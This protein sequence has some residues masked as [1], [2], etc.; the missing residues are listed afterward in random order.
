[1]IYIFR[2]WRFLRY[3]NKRSRKERP[4]EAP[5][6]HFGF[7]L[8]APDVIAGYAAKTGK[9]E[10][11]VQRLLKACVK[12]HYIDEDVQLQ[13]N[14]MDIKTLLWI[15]E[16]YG[17]AFLPFFSGLVNTEVK[18]FGAAAAILVSIAAGFGWHNIAKAVAR[19]F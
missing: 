14:G 15:D 11:D 1:M 18:T 4:S 8:Q 17:E 6:Y 2:Q 19:L 5:E 7:R 13:N 16:Q 9:S 3:L 10:V 12:S